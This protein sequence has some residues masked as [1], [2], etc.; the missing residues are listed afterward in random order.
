MASS[1][2][3]YI[4]LLFLQDRPLLDGSSDDVQAVTNAE[5]PFPAED[6][7]MAFQAAVSLF[8]NYTIPANRMKLFFWVLTPCRVGIYQQ[9]YTASQPWKSKSSLL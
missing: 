1:G 9:T 3:S 4:T 5:V 2:S 6:R 7:I 8:S